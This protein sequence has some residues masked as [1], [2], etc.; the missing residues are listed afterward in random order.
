[1]STISCRSNQFTHLIHFKCDGSRVFNIPVDLRTTSLRNASAVGLEPRGLQ[2]SNFCRFHPGQ[3]L[4]IVS[5][6]WTLLTFGRCMFENRA[7]IPLLSTKG[8]KHC[9]LKT[10]ISTKSCTQRLKG[11]FPFDRRLVTPYWY[12]VD[13][14][15]LF[16]AVLNG[17]YIYIYSNRNTRIVKNETS[18]LFY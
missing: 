5:F 6:R 13:Y 1:M 3:I 14:F 4:R 7:K 2:C 15:D 18:F 17:S 16:L 12:L 9:T 10:F 11:I 8:H